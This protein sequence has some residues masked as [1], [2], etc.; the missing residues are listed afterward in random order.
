LPTPIRCRAW[1]A[2]PKKL[3]TRV[4]RRTG[5][6]LGKLC[7]ECRPRGF[8]HLPAYL[9]FCELDFKFFRSV[10]WAFLCT[11][12][13]MSMRVY[14]SPNLRVNVNITK[15]DCRRR[16]FVD[17]VLD[18]GTSHRRGAIREKYGNEFVRRAEWRAWLH[19]SKRSRETLLR[20]YGR[21]RNNGEW[22]QDFRYWEGLADR[23]TRTD[24]E[25]GPRFFRFFRVFTAFLDQLGP[26]CSY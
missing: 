8:V 22:K 12:A 13:C 4:P 25:S 7:S 18:L 3:T 26:D 2:F 24:K 21:L 16:F 17:Y 1:Q 6:K 15:L 11:S 23:Q 20:P 19:Q 10:R 5:S 9:W 14:S